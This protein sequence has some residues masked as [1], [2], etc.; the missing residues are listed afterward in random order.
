MPLVVQEEIAE[1]VTKV[2]QQIKSKARTVDRFEAHGE[3]LLALN[4]PS[5]IPDVWY[6]LDIV[7]DND[8]DASI[9]YP[10]ENAFKTKDAAVYNSLDTYNGRGERIRGAQPAD[11]DWER[12]KIDWKKMK[13]INKA[14]K[15]YYAIRKEHGYTMLGPET[16]ALQKMPRLAVQPAIAVPPLSTKRRLS[17]IPSTLSRVVKRARVEIVED[18]IKDHK[19]NVDGLARPLKQLWT[20]SA[21]C[22]EL[23]NTQALL[24]QHF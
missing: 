5:I 10:E 8:I 14:N 24:S 23:N 9:V 15:V 13:H 19:R 16:W 17:P 3:Q 7:E 1:E 21:A 12:A 20:R 22:V 4:I 2:K 11:P 6:W 18:S